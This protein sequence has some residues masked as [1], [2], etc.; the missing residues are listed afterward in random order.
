MTFCLNP[1]CSRPQNPD[2]YQ[3]CSSCGSKL[4]LGDRYRALE[5]M[6]QEGGGRTF[7]GIDRDRSR[8]I[9]KQIT[10]KNEGESLADF[11]NEAQKLQTLGLHP[12]I[13]KLLA[14]FETAAN[15][16]HFPPTLV[17][18]FIE[19]QNIAKEIYDETTIQN[20]I[21]DILPIL[22]FVHDCHIVHRDINPQNFIRT[23]TGQLFLVDFSTAK[24][25]AKTALAKTGTMVGS[26]AYV[27]PEQLRGK[28]V[29][30]SDLY[31]LGVICIHL[32][33][34]FH[35]FDLF[36]SRE[37]RW[38]WEEYLANPVQPVLRNVLNKMLS[39]A[40]SDRYQS[41]DEI[42]RD[43]HPGQTLIPTVVQ[44][45]S[46]SQIGSKTAFSTLET[47][48]PS[49]SC[50]RTLEGHSSSVCA[51]AFHPDGKIL[52]S[53]G[54]D[55][56]I[57]FW[58]TDTGKRQFNIL[59]RH[60]SIIEAIVFQPQTN[61]IISGSWDYRICFWNYEEE[62]TEIEAHTGWIK[63]LAI[64]K[65]GQF[66]A[67][68]SADKTVKLWDIKTRELKQT[69]WGCEGEVRSL[70]FNPE[71]NLLIGGGADRAI[72][73]WEVD[74]PQ[75][76]QILQGHSGAVNALAM[77]P[78]GRILLSGSDDRTIRIWDLQQGIVQ[79][80]L[81]GHTDTIEALAMNG[82]GDLLVSG[83]GDRIGRIWHLGTGQLLHEL[84]G[85]TAGIEAIAIAPDNRT[86]A[87]A[88]RDKTIKLWQYR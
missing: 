67:S 56:V 6:I 10:V 3:F 53:G 59:K 54:A 13:P 47:L 71:G 79:Q 41:A 23:P 7:L 36:D 43:L 2:N 73:V 66:L 35:P 25:T 80:E 34:G 68:G 76:R 17:Q 70:I 58:D 30:A 65:S 26:A 50:F 28:S 1:Q 81:Q 57:R 12:N 20:L 44:P 64:A 61:L 49:W 85:H 39:D 86:I 22:Q 88:S 87:T 82:E 11:R 14:Y 18:E 40:V 9:I 62:L 63:T 60:S 37:G 69:L 4:L 19:G 51:L 42:Y 75:T 52:A 77:S 83:G 55:R 24:V 46:P 78:S 21:E 16:H 74:R 32:L 84:E 31:S 33:T 48:Q 38:H 27:A 29:Y 5:P 45:R 8:C 15:I 72:R